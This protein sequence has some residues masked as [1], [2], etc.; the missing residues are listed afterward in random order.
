MQL[1]IDRFEGSEGLS[2]VEIEL[3][4]GR[5]RASWLCPLHGGDGC[6]TPDGTEA[7]D[8]DRDVRG[9]ASQ[10]HDVARKW[11]G[12][13]YPGASRIREGDLPE[14]EL[15]DSVVTFRSTVVSLI[16]SLPVAR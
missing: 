10:L 1:C 2:H 11:R 8:R 14:G 3:A 13:A 6:R 4:H 7:G 5:G 9:H 15:K 16:C 12:F